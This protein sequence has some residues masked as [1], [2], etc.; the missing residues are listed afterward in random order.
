M[1]EQ[2]RKSLAAAGF[3]DNFKDC[4]Y[5]DYQGT[6]RWTAQNPETKIWGYV[7]YEYG[8]CSVCDPTDGWTDDDYNEALSIVHEQDDEPQ[9]C[10]W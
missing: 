3:T 8:S 9:V 10:S 4:S 7:G 6:M 5:R 1:E 2:A